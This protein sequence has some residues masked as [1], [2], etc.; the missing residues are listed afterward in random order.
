LTKTTKTL[1]RI[2]C[3]ALAAV[4]LFTAAA[5]ATAEDNAAWTFRV[6]PYV[7][8]PALESSLAIGRDP[9]AETSTSVLDIL[10]G[11][12]LLGGEAR[13]GRFALIGEFNYL[14][15]SDRAEGPGGRVGADASI[16][17]VMG[18]L[19][20]AFTVVDGPAWRVESLAGLRVWSLDAAVDFD[21]LR[22]AARSKTWVDP[23]VGA[24]ASYALTDT[25]SLQALGNVGGFGLGSDLQWEVIGRAGW[26]LSDTF[27][28][29]AGYRHLAVDF[30][31]DGLLLDMT[32]TGP[33]IALDVTF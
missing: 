28:V 30:D 10:D 33:F 1:L 2:A 24:R 17:G 12:L 13:R 16:E 3:S 18:A 5:P 21:N 9:P 27:T 29:A 26:R 20:G 31:N 25:I 32:L 7:W 11:A 14:N 22:P 19:T 15:L 6:T 4:T 23:L 8:A